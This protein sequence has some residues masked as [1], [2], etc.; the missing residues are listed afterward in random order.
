MRSIWCGARS[1]RRTISTVPPLERLR[2]R[3]FEGLAVT[4][5]GAAMPGAGGATGAGAAA[6][7]NAA[8]GTANRSLAVISLPD[9]D[10]IVCA[11]PTDLIVNHRGADARP[12]QRPASRTFR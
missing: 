2:N 10:P 9:V 8:N 7:N 5:A 1:G 6:I 11:R 12:A 3:W 4:S